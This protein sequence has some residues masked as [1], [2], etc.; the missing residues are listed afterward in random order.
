[1]AHL[2]SYFALFVLVILVFPV[3]V[4][5][6]DLTYNADTTVDLSSPDVDV[7]ILSG[8][9]A[10]SVVVG[11]GSV[12][13]T[14]PASSKFYL[15][16]GSR[17]LSAIDT[18]TGAAS[19]MTVINC[20]DGTATATITATAATTVEIFPTAL[21]CAS[22][23]GG[24]GGSSPSPAPTPPAGGPTPTPAPAPT[25]PPSG[26]T[27]AP[28]GAHPNGT[29]INDN[30]TIYLVVNG[31][32]RGFRNPEEYMSHGYKFSQAVTANSTDRA[33]PSEAQAIE[34]ALDGTLALDKTDNRTIYMIANGQKRGFTS[35]AVFQ[36]LGY[37]FDQ[38]VAI[39]LADYPAG[40]VIDSVAPAHPDGAL[41][42]DKNDKRTVWWILGG[43][44]KGFQSL[45]VFNT[46][47]FDLGKI[48]PANDSD[49]ALPQGDLV[50]FRD[51]TLVNDAG[52]Y[53][54]ISD[55]AKKR[56]PHIDILKLKG[57]KPENAINASL[58]AYADGGTVE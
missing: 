54:L 53:H 34:K 24:G 43:Q 12:K 39:N 2:K 30:G 14:V 40:P 45:E 3:W 36:G 41:V 50:K 42:L 22:G 52:V 29:L 56:F 46:Y 57:Y 51:G 15:Q 20:V 18:S 58:S 6:A 38:A 26:P 11:T 25:P 17:G 4:S 13:A 33:L 28:A 35:A 19:T 55:G 37:R 5:A 31:K 7:T 47:G 23:G 16:S 21:Q 48:V 32:K 1:M 44:R 8:S 10:T 27:P 9:E 49:M